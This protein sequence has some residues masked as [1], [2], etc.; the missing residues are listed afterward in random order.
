MEH[1][2]CHYNIIFFHFPVAIGGIA[3]LCLGFSL[4]SFTE[5]VFFLLV[6]IVK[7]CKR[8]KSKSNNDLRVNA[9]N[10]KV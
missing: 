1:L 5:V 8:L 2:K 9:F 3:G 7:I 6:G 4:I 10:E